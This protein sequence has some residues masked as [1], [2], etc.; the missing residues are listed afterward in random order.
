MVVFW[1]GGAVWLVS[2]SSFFMS[3]FGF[4]WYCGFKLK[5]RLCGGLFCLLV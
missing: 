4:D 5:F 3:F 2:G 1:M